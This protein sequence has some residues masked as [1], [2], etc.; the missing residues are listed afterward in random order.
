MAPSEADPL[1]WIIRDFRARQ[2]SWWKVEKEKQH[3]EGE[4]D[5]SEQKKVPVFYSQVVV[6]SPQYC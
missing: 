6:L 4:F 3:C 5:L 2:L 1:L